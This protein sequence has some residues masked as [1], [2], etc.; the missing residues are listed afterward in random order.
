[1]ALIS[2]RINI[3]NAR[4]SWVNTVVELV[5]WWAIVERSRGWRNAVCGGKVVSDN[6]RHEKRRE[7]E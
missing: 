4:R 7:S 5:R 3:E 1:M 2:L 6:F